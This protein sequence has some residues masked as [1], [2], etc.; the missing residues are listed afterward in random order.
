MSKRLFDDSDLTV[1]SQPKRLNT[2][3][4][5]SVFSGMTLGAVSNDSILSTVRNIDRKSDVAAENNMAVQ[6]LIQDLARRSDMTNSR[7]RTIQLTLVPQ[8]LSAISSVAAKVDSMTTGTI[9]TIYQDVTSL[10]HNVYGMYDYLEDQVYLADS[11]PFVVRRLGYLAN[12]DVLGALQTELV[13]SVTQLES[14]GLSSLGFPTPLQNAIYQVLADM[15]SV[16]G[17]AVGFT[18]TLQK[19]SDT[20]VRSM[21]PMIEALLLG[22]YTTNPTFL[23]S[24]SVPIYLPTLALNVKG[25]IANDFVVAFPEITGI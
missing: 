12:H 10:F 9:G 19:I 23:T 1:E 4:N 5:T 24:A 20:D 15:N 2:N 17:F 7:V 18:Y 8:I 13:A 6:G 11:S 22:N 16:T 21:V 3:T 14:T 25:L